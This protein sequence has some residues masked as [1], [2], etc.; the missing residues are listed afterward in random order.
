MNGL[1]EPSEYQWIFGNFAAAGGEIDFSLFDQFKGNIDNQRD[2]ILQHFEKIG[3][4]LTG[5][6]N[7]LLDHIQ[8]LPIVPQ[9]FFHDWGLQEPRRAVPSLGA[10]GYFAYAFGH[11][12]YGIHPDSDIKREAI[13][14]LQQLL[15]PAGTEV[16][17]YD[18]SCEELLLIAP[19]YYSA[20]AEWW[21]V[22]LFTIQIP[23]IRRLWVA[24]ASATD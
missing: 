12:P 10:R 11:P 7:A 17:P 8:S 18:W 23:L 1:V 3:C 21:G 16:Y 14:A 22:F 6:A 13:Q 20:G 2:C 19:D 24:S 5:D 9:T 15:R 4:G